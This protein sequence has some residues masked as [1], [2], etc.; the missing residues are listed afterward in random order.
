MVCLEVSAPAWEEFNP[1][2]RDFIQGTPVKKQIPQSCLTNR[3]ERT[4]YLRDSSKM[5]LKIARWVITILVQ[6]HTVMPS[7][8]SV[9]NTWSGPILW[10]MAAG[11][12]GVVFQILI[13]IVLN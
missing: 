1:V 13:E 6:R 8:P 11:K 2:F 9:E 12:V 3:K 7:F 4:F 10:A 5:S